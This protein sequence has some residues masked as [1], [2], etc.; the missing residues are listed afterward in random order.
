MQI[1][2]AKNRERL[3][4]FVAE[5][6]KTKQLHGRYIN[7]IFHSRQFNFEESYCEVDEHL[8]R[9]DVYFHPKDSFDKWVDVF[10]LGEAKIYEAMELHSYL[11]KTPIDFD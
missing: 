5:M 7:Y 11:K 8:C 6:K 10:V 3:E 1:V 4:K 9:V 2:L